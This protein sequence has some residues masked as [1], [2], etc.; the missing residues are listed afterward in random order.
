MLPDTY[1][2][3]VHTAIWIQNGGS[4]TLKSF[5]ITSLK[6]IEPKYID[7]PLL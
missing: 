7:F 2:N 6:V 5:N 4:E 3:E 1:N